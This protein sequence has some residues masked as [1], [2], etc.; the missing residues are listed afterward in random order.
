MPLDDVAPTETRPAQTPDRTQA[1]HKAAVIYRIRA[2]MEFWGVSVDDLRR[3]RG[4][5]TPMPATAPVI[6]YRHPTTGDTWDGRGEQPAWLRQAL[7]K[8]GWTVDEL[9]RAAETAPT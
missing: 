3:H 6:K 5:P 4:P 7:L 1:R 2:L 9:R 8:E